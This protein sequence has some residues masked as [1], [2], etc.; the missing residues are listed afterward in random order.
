MSLSSRNIVI[1]QVL[2]SYTGST[3][4]NS[5]HYTV[6]VYT[7]NTGHIYEVLQVIPSLSDLNG[8][9]LRS[10]I[11]INISSL[12]SFY[13]TVSLN[14]EYRISGVSEPSNSIMISEQG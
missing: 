5:F 6:S 14:N 2:V 10:M 3:N 1:L 7:S 4:I 8:T 11:S 12:G 9:E 13:F